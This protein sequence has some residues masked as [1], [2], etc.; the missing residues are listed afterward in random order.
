MLLIVSLIEKEMLHP[1]PS[2]R[3]SA[4]A[5]LQ[6]EFLVQEK[7]LREQLVEQQ[8]LYAELQ[9]EL[10]QYKDYVKLLSQQTQMSGEV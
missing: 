1:D 7:S 10:T 2:K 9:R 4:A 5:L 3:P 8:Q 6:H